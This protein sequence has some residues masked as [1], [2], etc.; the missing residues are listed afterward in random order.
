MKM[1]CCYAFIMLIIVLFVLFV[2][3]VF[4]CIQ[5][6]NMKKSFSN[7]ILYLNKPIDDIKHDAI[8]VDAYVTTL[9]ASIHNDAK[10]IAL[11]SDYGGGKSSVISLLEKRINSK[12]LLKKYK[13]CRLNLWE[14]SADQSVSLHENFIY[15]LATSIKPK[16]GDYL[17][18]RISNKYKTIRLI[19]S[20]TLLSYAP[21][22]ILSILFYYFIDTVKA[23]TIP[24]DAN[25]VYVLVKAIQ[26]V[27]SIFF[28]LLILGIILVF[29]LLSSGISIS[30]PDGKDMSI[31][32]EIMNLYHNFI[33][34]TCFYKRNY[35]VVVEDLDRDNDAETVYSFLK[36]LKKYHNLNTKNKYNNVIFI[37]CLK[38]EQLLETNKENKETNKKNKE[39]S[40]IYPKLFDYTVILQ[41][42]NID[43]YDAVLESLLNEQIENLKNIGIV[44]NDI[45]KITISDIPYIEYIIRG[46]KIDIRQIKERLNYALTLYDS[47]SNKFDDIE[48]EKCIIASYIIHEYSNDYYNMSDNMFDDY[49]NEQLRSTEKVLENNEHIFSKEVKI[50]IEK[51]LIDSDYRTYFFNYPKNSS[52][53]SFEE[54]SVRDII[55]KNSE[56]DEN[57]HI[58]SKSVYEKNK[59]II[60]AAVKRYLTYSLRIPTLAFKDEYICKA[61]IESSDLYPSFVDGLISYFKEL[62]STNS[63][64]FNKTISSFIKFNIDISLL[65]RLSNDAFMNLPNEIIIEVRSQLIKHRENDI[66]KFK[67]LFLTTKPLICSDEINSINALNLIPELININ[68]SGLHTVVL[69]SLDA[70]LSGHKNIPEDIFNKFFTDLINKKDR[71]FKSIHLIVYMHSIQKMISD[72]EDKVVADISSGKLDKKEYVGLINDVPAESFSE[73]T[74][75]HIKDLKI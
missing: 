62:Y 59:S 45:N 12:K 40:N 44:N 60:V 51:N 3:F 13:F 11:V 50:L 1:Y 37:I 17:F 18:T 70:K 29:M 2:L 61:S 26:S 21:V 58:K 22:F 38:P 15:Q 66:L 6:Q 71:N 7:S 36:E 65:E 74:I 4:H 8:D 52:L 41:K 67:D 34:K 19:S 49:L 73:N 31:E 16:L 54:R 14:S 30:N 28:V 25:I 23:I 63:E 69:P 75:K 5:K 47:L 20:H 24:N 57:F 53:Y 35:I 39:P 48:F 55:L 27:P 9:M 64:L 68:H 43:N 42:V 46:E 72:L 33:F 32:T 56:P 10:M